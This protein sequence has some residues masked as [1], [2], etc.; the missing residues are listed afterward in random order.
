[1]KGEGRW[2][3]SGR[4]GAKKIAVCAEFIQETGSAGVLSHADQRLAPIFP[5]KTRLLLACAAFAAPVSAQPALTIYNQNFAV[6]RERVPLD[7]KPGL[8]AVK[9]TGATRMLEPDSVVLR[10]PRGRVALRVLEQSYRADTLS[11]GF[12]LSLHE[13]KELD[14]L[15]RDQ[16]GRENVVRGKV[17]RSGH[18]TAG[19]AGESPIIE[20]EG[21][22]RFSLPGEP[23]FPALSD[24][25]VLKP[26]LTWQLEGERAGKLEA[27]LGYVTGGFK[28]EAAY[29]LIAPEKGDTL[30][31][32][33]W[34]TVANTSGQSFADA[35]IKL[36][37]G[38][39]QKIQPTP[40]TRMRGEG[41]Q[42]QAFSVGAAVT[43]KAFDEFHLYSLPR[44]VTLRD[45]ETKQ[46]EFMRTTG[47][48]A[49]VAYVYDGARHAT[50][51]AV[52][53]EFRNSEQIGLGLP[54]PKGRTRFYRKDDA[55]G[56][57]EFVGEDTIDHT[58]KNEWV[59]V[60]TGD[61]FDIVGERRALDLSSSMSQ[62]RAE[63][64]FEIKLRNRKSAPVE[65]K[66]VEHLWG[67]NWEMVQKSDDYTKRDAATIE[68]KVEVKP[69]QERIVTYHVRYDW[70]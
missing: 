41:I 47:V 13:G 36:M 63:Q 60:K 16:N 2:P 25:G 22:L 44:A 24:A 67:G 28:W 35:T 51:V 9:F 49:P 42:L 29:N 8:N 34:I 12:L 43:E 20:V 59:R 30:D 64:R 57:I 1:M 68:F 54:L 5:M 69:D 15:V 45:R 32:V 17:V 39:V 38:D 62:G 65:V 27:E 70:K 23:I 55:D 53:R 52:M 19:G 18:A 37:A 66:V 21:K 56:R 11:Q 33:G 48:K 3:Q 50:K 7:L 10:D 6:V 14:F 61:A 46:V 31:V 58:A 40:Q 26:T 4:R